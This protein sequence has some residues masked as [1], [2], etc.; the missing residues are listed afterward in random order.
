MCVAL[1]SAKEQYPSKVLV[2]HSH[3]KRFHTLFQFPNA[4]GSVRHVVV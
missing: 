3:Q 2:R 4:A 1:V